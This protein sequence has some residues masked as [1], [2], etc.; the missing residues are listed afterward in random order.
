M[1]P[2]CTQAALSKTFMAHRHITPSRIP[3]IHILYHSATSHVPALPIYRKR[4]HTPNLN[5]A[6]SHL[7]VH[8][9]S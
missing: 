2:L 4:A 3:N 8:R 7:P 6:A 1:S 5:H 9:S